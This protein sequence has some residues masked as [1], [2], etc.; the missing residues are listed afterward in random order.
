[1]NTAAESSISTHAWNYHHELKANGTDRDAIAV[2]SK[3]AKMLDELFGDRAIGKFSQ[4]NLRTFRK[5]L[6]KDSPEYGAR[7]MRML[8]AILD[9]AGCWQESFWHRSL[10]CGKHKKGSAFLR[11]YLKH[12]TCCDCG[13]KRR[14]VLKR[15]D[16]SLYRNGLTNCSLETIRKY[17]TECDVRC[18]SCVGKQVAGGAS[19]D[20]IRDALLSFK[21]STQIVAELHT[22]AIRVQRVAEA[23]FKEG[24]AC[25]CGQRLAHRETC[26]IRRFTESIK[27][28]FEEMPPKETPTVTERDNACRGDKACPF[29][30]YR[31]GLCRKHLQDMAFSMSMTDTALDFMDYTITP[32]NPDPLLSL[33]VGESRMRNP[34]LIFE[35]NGHYS[36]VRA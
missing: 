23:M 17:I 2:S 6:D 7:K 25:I 36:E 5:E 32:D 18:Q 11:E 9:R 8:R 3:V 26:D 14:L 19:D 28:T 21:T 33:V 20:A 24:H 27:V 13:S 35:R 15:K 16:G 10:P 12:S 4:L 29:A 22:A 1:M 31:D 30:I 34:R